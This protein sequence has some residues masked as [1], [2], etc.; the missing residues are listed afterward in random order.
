MWS[1]GEVEGLATAVAA[2]SHC[3]Q[4]IIITIFLS[5]THTHVRARVR[6][7]TPG[8]FLEESKNFVLAALAAL[9]AL[10]RARPYM[11]LGPRWEKVARTRDVCERGRLC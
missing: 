6:T 7:R 2:P 8:R 10:N 3:C 11:L 5:H 1:G 9:G 4:T